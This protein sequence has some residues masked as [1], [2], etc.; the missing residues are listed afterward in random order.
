MKAEKRTV[1]RRACELV[2]DGSVIGLGTGSTVFYFIERLGELVADGL[3]VAGVPTSRATEEVARRQGVPLTTLEEHPRLS[4]DVDGADEISPSLDLIKGGGG[5]LTREKVVAAASERF[6]VIAEGSKLV[7]RLGAFPL[8]VEVI[9][10]GWSATARAV[11][12]TGCRATLRT[13]DGS[14][15]ITDNGNYI[16]DCEYGV[17]DDPGPLEREL[18]VVPGVVESG[19]FVGM[20]TS[21]LVGEGAGVRTL[22]R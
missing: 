13:V 22:T 2:E 14:P 16:I 8:P 20:A 10:F 18:A 12:G 11:E 21:A 9:P 4:L 3:E 5:A 17:I 7:G 15:F 1:G 6:V 19:L